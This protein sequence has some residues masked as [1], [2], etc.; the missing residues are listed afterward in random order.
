MSTSYFAIAETK[1]VVPTPL[2]PLMHRQRVHDLLNQSGT[3]PVTLLSAPAGY[4][5]TCALSDW[6]ATSKHSFAWLSLD[7]SDNTVYRFWLSLFLALQRSAPALIEP[8]L[9]LWQEQ[10]QLDLDLRS[11][12]ALLINRLLEERQ[13]HYVLILDNYQCI[14]EPA[15]HQQIDYLIEWL[16][17]QLRLVLVTRVDPPLTL[18]RLRA[19]GR[20]FEVSADHLRCTETETAVFLQK[21][22]HLALPYEEV[23]QI[24]ARTQGWLVGLHLFGRSFQQ[25]QNLVSEKGA[26][27][28]QDYLIEE[29]FSQQEE[30]LQ[31]F[32]LLTCLFDQFSVSL[33]DALW[34]EHHSSPLLDVL[35]RRH[36]FVLHL[37]TEGVWYRYHPLFGEALRAY[38]HQVRTPEEID[39]LYCKARF[40]YARQEKMGPSLVQG[41]AAQHVSQQFSS[42]LKAVQMQ[43]GWIAPSEEPE[44]YESHALKPAVHAL[45]PQ[46]CRAERVKHLSLLPEQKEQPRGEMP[47]HIAPLTAREQEVLQ[48]LA[49]GASNQEISNRLV[50]AQNT[51]KRHVHTILEKLDAHNRT[52][53]V[54]RAQQFHLLRRPDAE[55][56]G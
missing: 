26:H 14:T 54:L 45:V 24:T 12:L 2:R 7:A 20:L 47:P 19:Q 10:K 48:L 37:D 32:L 5:K 43:S 52:Q 9:F 8:L 42:S 39:A 56:M 38:A 27:A 36:L 44:R 15:I 17:P 1:C 40:W 51:A 50:I 4:G 53:A 55:C 31:E 33:C 3:Y 11:L 46:E 35:K 22:M 25:G 28:I 13:N 41:S 49:Q 6:V 30:P 16:P 34:D 23:E 21:V 29:I 18:P